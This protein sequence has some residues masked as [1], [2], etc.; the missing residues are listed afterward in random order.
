MR[1]IRRRPFV[2]VLLLAAA[3]IARA[4]PVPEPPPKAPS[5][6]V[7]QAHLPAF[8]EP[9]YDKAVEALIAAFEAATG[10]RLAPGREEE[11]RV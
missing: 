1:L 8:D 5:A 9:S 3:A 7:W 2:L 6:P 11:G 4:Q 10:R